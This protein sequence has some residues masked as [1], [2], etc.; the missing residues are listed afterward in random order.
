MLTPDTSHERMFS[1]STCSME[2]DHRPI[3][4][5][6]N[7]SISKTDPLISVL[8]KQFFA[9]FPIFYLV[10]PP[11]GVDLLGYFWRKSVGQAFH[12]VTSDT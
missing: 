3:S 2:D 1:R 8:G 10:L 12:S 9:N 4:V 11:I 7:T 6:H 5:C